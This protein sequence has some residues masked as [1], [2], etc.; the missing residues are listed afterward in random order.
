MFQESNLT[1]NGAI[2][3]ITGALLV[4]Y[5]NFKFGIEYKTN[6]ENILLKM[7]IKYSLYNSLHF[8]MI[9][10][11]WFY[12]KMNPFKAKTFKN[13][14][15]KKNQ[16]GLVHYKNVRLLRNTYCAFNVVSKLYMYKQPTTKSKNVKDPRSIDMQ[17]TN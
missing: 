6:K 10:H 2:S 1:I 3:Q 4:F 7:F 15:M 12:N 8:S 16:N 14:N 13:L 5:W 11:H 17:F 9:P